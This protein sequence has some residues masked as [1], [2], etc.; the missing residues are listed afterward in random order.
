MKLSCILVS[1]LLSGL[2]AMALA[3]QSP[4]P[5]FTLKDT[6]GV[7]HQLSDSQ[8]KVV[9]LEW[10][11]KDCPYVKKHYS[12]KN[13]QA[14]QKK[15]TGQGIVWYSIMSSAPGKQGFEL[16]TEAQKTR[17]SLDVHSTATLLDPDGKVGHLYEAKTTP[18]IFVIDSKGTLAYNGA[19]DD[20]DS[21]DSSDIPK[22]KNFLASAVDELL[23]QK[24]VSTATTK[25]YGC[26]VKYQ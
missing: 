17:Q 16:A 1:V 9:V 25:P 2:Q 20:N 11:N 5:N 8:G 24:P 4:A 3:V 26:S 7:S 22:S 14:L 21:S 10:F 15:Y 19:I 23:A 13:M 12:V 18:H 6:A